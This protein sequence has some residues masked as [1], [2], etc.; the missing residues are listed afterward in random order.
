MVDIAAI[1]F[2]TI[3]LP[4]GIFLLVK[5][6]KKVIKNKKTK[7]LGAECFAMI[8]GIYLTGTYMNT[9]ENHNNR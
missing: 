7:K 2:F 9:E 6:L 1:S 5:G 3:F 4:Q 8:E